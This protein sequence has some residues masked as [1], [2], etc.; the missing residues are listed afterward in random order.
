VL[1]GPSARQRLPREGSGYPFALYSVD[2]H[3]S[4]RSWRAASRRA[5]RAT[6]LS[7]RIMDRCG[8]HSGPI[9]RAWAPPR[10]TRAGPCRS[11]TSAF[12]RSRGADSWWWRSVKRSSPWSIGRGTSPYRSVAA[13]GRRTRGR[14]SYARSVSGSLR[15]W[16]DHRAQVAAGPPDCRARSAGK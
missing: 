14:H 10:C 1:I 12:G 11:G 8:S 3:D 5:D 2:G 7:I 6:S 15:S 9:Y 16:P 13:G 4:C